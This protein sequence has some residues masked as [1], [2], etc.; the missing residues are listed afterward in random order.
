MPWKSIRTDDLLVA[1]NS[2]NDQNTEEITGP[3]SK[4]NM[5]LWVN[6]GLP[7]RRDRPFGVAFRLGS[8]GDI[9]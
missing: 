6:T 4:G 5:F 9:H 8:I 1:R 7:L 3:E 2:G